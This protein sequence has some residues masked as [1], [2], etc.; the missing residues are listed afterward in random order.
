MTGLENELVVFDIRYREL[1]D[2]E[3]RQFDTVVRL[4]RLE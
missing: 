4:F 3:I 2:R 1:R